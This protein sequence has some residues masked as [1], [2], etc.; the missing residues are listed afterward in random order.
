MRI[1]IIV[2]AILSGAIVSGL[3]GFFLP[4][5][6]SVSS[7]N[8]IGGPASA[9]WVIAI[10]TIPLGALGGAILSGILVAKKLGNSTGNK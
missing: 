5:L 7:G 6:L 4:L 3:A 8:V 9:G 2:L 1:I 10:I